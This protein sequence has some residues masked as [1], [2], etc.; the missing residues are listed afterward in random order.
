MPTATPEASK[1]TPASSLDVWPR[2][3]D[4]LPRHLIGVSRDMQARV[5]DA[6]ATDHGYG[7]LRMSFGPFLSLVWDE[8]RPITAIAQELSISKQACSQLANLAEAAGYL[9]RT[10][11]PQDARSKVVRLT[12][13]GRLMIERGAQLILEAE[14]GYAALV[15]R[16][17]YRQ[18]TVALQSLYLGLGLTAHAL[19]AATA[20]QKQ[21]AGVLPLVS[22]TVQR[23]LMESN[24]A[25]G[26]KGLK[27]SH[28][29]VLPFIG[30]DGGH[31]H[32]IARIQQVSRQAISAISL[33][34]E[35]LGYLR[36]TKDP[37]DKRGVVLLL[38]S[39][40]A[41]LIEDSVTAV[42]ELEADLERILT[43]GALD[44][45]REVA[46]D[47][48]RALHLEREIFESLTD[49]STRGV[50]LSAT[51]DAPRSQPHLS[52]KARADA[53]KGNNIVQIAESLR[54]QLNPVETAHLAELLKSDARRT[55]S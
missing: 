46:R 41:A 13:H 3:R 43:G 49:E 6:L 31:I 26:H 36:R 37:H 30:A 12:R 11:N 23:R 28:G 44:L 19:P 2:Y 7:D 20:Q 15:G 8:G 45:V 55:T 4:N 25:R 33:D 29:Q 22:E 35:A 54:L 32:E 50:D 10:T 42:E 27:M 53:S 5:M 24:T 38:T 47:L 48:Y 21:S 40:G 34:L 9:A 39:Q 14:A 17:R 51:S 18:F 16:E 52:R 1:L